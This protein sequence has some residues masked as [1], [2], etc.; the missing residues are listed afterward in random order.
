MDRRKFFRRGLSE[1]FKPLA[2]AIAPLE[3]AANHIGQLENLTSPPSRPSSSQQQHT[4]PEHTHTP[5]RYPLNIWLRPPGAIAEK[6]FIGTCSR[7]GECV[8]ACPAQCIMIDPSDSQGNG[9]P[10]IQADLAAC[11]VCDGLYCMHACP[12]GAL[13][14]ASITEIDMGTAVWKEDSCIRA[15]GRDC[16]ICVD[17]CPIGETAIKV[18]DTTIEVNPHGCVG[19]GMCQQYCPTQ[20]KSIFVIAKAAKQRA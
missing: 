7:G 20:P 17:K 8:K 2:K 4:Q 3:R 11:T 9:V 13:V 18:V 14:P 6:E 1:L 15:S 16:R 10:Y 12:S 19:C 5:Q